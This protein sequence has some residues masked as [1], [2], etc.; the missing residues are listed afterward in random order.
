MV[1]GATT[2]PYSLHQETYAL[3]KNKAST[4]NHQ[5]QQNTN[6]MMRW[7]QEAPETLSQQDRQ[8]LGG[9]EQ[10]EQEGGTLLLLDIHLLMVASLCQE[11]NR[12]GNKKEIG[13]PVRDLDSERH[14]VKKT[15]RRGH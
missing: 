15:V 14:C 12:G 11:S 5:E 2:R 3:H 1:T 4:S 8:E 13:C 6:I 7:Q 9:E 10:Q